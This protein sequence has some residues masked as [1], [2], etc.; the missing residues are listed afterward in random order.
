MRHKNDVNWRQSDVFIV[1]FEQIKLTYWF[2]KFEHV[3]TYWEI[4][5]VTLLSREKI[6]KVDNKITIL[7]CSSAQYV[8]S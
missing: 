4:Y 3:I 8:Q 6:L 5:L 1:N 2:D 7:I